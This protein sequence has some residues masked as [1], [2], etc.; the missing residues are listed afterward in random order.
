MSVVFVTRSELGLA[1]LEALEDSGA[2][3]SAVV[4]RPENENISD[5]AD[6]WSFAEGRDVALHELTDVNAPDSQAAI[7]DYDP[8]L[9]FVVGWSRLV[10][11]DVI[12]IPSEAA[13]GMHPAPLPRGRGRAPLA[14]PLIKGLDETALTMFHLVEEADAG[15]IVGQRPIPIDLEDDVESLYGK[16]LNAG[17][18]L[19]REFYPRLLEDGSVGEPQDH[20]AATW[21]P[22]RTPDHGLVDWTRSPMAVYNWI[23]GQ[24]KP[25]PGAYSYLGGQKV[26]ILEANPPDEERN[27]VQPGELHSRDDGVLRI[28]AFEGLVELTRV[29][30]D[31]EEFVASALPERVGVEVGDQFA[32]ARDLPAGPES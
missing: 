29:S 17:R 1:C 31:G 20:V 16:V 23:R 3:I 11:E 10:T 5:Q 21:W 2:D 15:D 7:A 26:T 24:S 9:L 8:D 14:W 19:I 12:S 32:N 28:G 25:Y 22:K 4:T 27:F 30:V 6:V 13:L 18:G